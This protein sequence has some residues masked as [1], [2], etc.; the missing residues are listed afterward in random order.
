[1]AQLFHIKIDD[2]DVIRAINSMSDA[3]K[4][5]P[6]VMR[7]T[8]NDLRRTLGSLAANQTGPDGRWDDREEG[9]DARAKRRQAKVK[10]GRK[11]KAGK[12][13]GA[14]QSVSFLGG[15]KLLGQLPD[16]V[17]Y[18]ADALSATARSPVPWAGAHNEGATVGR[19]SK[20]PK[21]TFVWV[22]PEVLQR[23]VKRMLE[24]VIEAARK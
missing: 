11:S 20:L 18:K 19:G 15:K 9:A 21:R 13:S 5:F 14:R 10:R 22:P 7:Q 8:S 3:G 24:K 1:M 12:R 17:S 23:L 16:T 6:K 2:T 4:N